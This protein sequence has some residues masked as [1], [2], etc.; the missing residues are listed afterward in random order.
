MDDCVVFQ[1]I[2]RETKDL[3]GSEKDEWVVLLH[4]NRWF[5]LLSLDRTKYVARRTQL[6]EQLRAV[7]RGRKSLKRREH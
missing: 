5:S 2:V 3:V 6:H 4:A 7:G 1:H